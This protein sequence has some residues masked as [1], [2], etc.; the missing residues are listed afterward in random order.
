MVQPYARVNSGWA[1]GACV[2]GVASLLA[3]SGFVVSMITSADAVFAII[4]PFFFLCPPLGLISGILALAEIS[5]NR[6]NLKGR[7]M[8]L[9]GIIPGAIGILLILMPLFIPHGRPVMKTSCLNNLK[10]IGTAINMYEADWDDRYPL[11]SGPGREFERVYGWTYNY[12]TKSFHGERRWLQNV[13]GPYAKNKKVFICPKVR[14]GQAWEIPGRGTVNYLYN[15]HG[16]FT[17]SVDSKPV[18]GPPSDSSPG[19]L[20]FDCDPPTSY[21]FNAYVTKP[22]KPDKV[23][24]GRSEEICYKTADA[25]LVWDTPCGFDNGHGESQI[26]HEDIINVCYADGHAKPYQIPRARSK[27]WLEGDFRLNHGSDG[28]YP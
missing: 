2:C 6:D 17:S 9:A 25:P 22:G 28:W 21:W 14:E 1:V 11:V 15:R 5:R 20:Q 7:G 24:S 12:R 8:A 10:Q 26:A 16:G 23:V 13:V 18:A 4:V 3:L 19:K 27:E